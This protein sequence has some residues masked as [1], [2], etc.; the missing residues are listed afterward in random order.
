MWYG[1]FNNNNTTAFKSIL[2]YFYVNLIM[3]T[4]LRNY[5]IS[6]KAS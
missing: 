3:G 6:D 5:N 1:F 4:N 2:I